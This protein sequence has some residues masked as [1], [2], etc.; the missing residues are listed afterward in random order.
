MPQYIDQD[1]I[2][3]PHLLEHVSTV[4]CSESS[5][6][7]LQEVGVFQS[8]PPQEGPVSLGDAVQQADD[9]F[10][11]ASW[12]L[13]SLYGDAKAQ[14]RKNPSDEKAASALLFVCPD[15]LTAWNVRKARVT[16]DR[17]STELKF[18]QLILSRNPKSGETWAHRGWVLRNF[19]CGIS[20]LEEELILLWKFVSRA[21]SNYY[22]GVHRMRIIPHVASESISKEL[23]R[24]RK[25]LQ[26]HVGDASGWWYHRKLLEMLPN[27]DPD[28]A[29]EEA[30]WFAD[31]RQRYGSTYQNVSLHSE[32]AARSPRSGQKLL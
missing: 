1:N 12:C 27:S 19:E 14:L 13:A 29:R 9:H 7:S 17:A 5:L 31:M 26:S 2:S 10:G 25:W 30:I 20:Q 21:A 6:N 24:S 22:A 18:S 11:V 28:I 15:S 4:L 23:Y 16:V 32:S 8:M 3:I